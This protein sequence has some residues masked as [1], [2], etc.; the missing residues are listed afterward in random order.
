MQLKAAR[1]AGARRRQAVGSG[2][3]EN[4]VCYTALQIVAVGFLAL[5]FL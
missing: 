2:H 3:G 1:L 4:R 5:R